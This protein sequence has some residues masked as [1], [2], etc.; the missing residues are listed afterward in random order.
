[1]GNISEG[2]GKALESLTMIVDGDFKDAFTNERGNRLAF[3]T[4]LGTRMA[5]ITGLL[6]RSPNMRAKL[7]GYVM[8]GLMIGLGFDMLLDQPANPGGG[9]PG[10]VN[11]EMN[12][13]DNSGVDMTVPI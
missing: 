5:G 11:D 10:P 9:D 12:N 2:M 4:L 8:D 1:L 7:A 3:F 13:V 6:K